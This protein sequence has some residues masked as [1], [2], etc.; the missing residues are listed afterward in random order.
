VSH[1]ERSCGAGLNGNCGPA[2]NDIILPL[3]TAQR[4]IWFAQQLDPSNPFYCFG[5]YIEIQG[6]LDPILFERAL[7]QVVFETEA[8]RVTIVEGVDGPFQVVS[9]TAEWSM[10]LI[11]VSGEADPRAAAESWMKT[12]LARPVAPTRGPLFGYALFKASPDHFFWY[13]RY[14]HIVMDGVGMC[15]VA[16]RL[17]DIYTRLVAGRTAPDCPFGAL[18]DL[19]GDDAAYRISE[20][21]ARDRQFWSDC[22]A[23]RPEPLSLGAN[24][25]RKSNGFVRR[26]GWLTRSSLDQL[27]SIATRAGTDL[28][29]VMTAAAAI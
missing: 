4:G 25:A 6:P 24:P 15:L 7:R 12:D 19:V 20:Q 28:P 10:P 22:L 26:S 9:A 18:A 27:G 5:E 16:R 13:A 1:L 3:T 2:R 11:D 14:H 29:P 8:L 21:F 17:A 23:D